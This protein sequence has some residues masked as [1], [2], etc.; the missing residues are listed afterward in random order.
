MVLLP[1]T[2]LLAALALDRLYELTKRSLVSMN[3]RATFVA[4]IAA[5]LLFLGMG[6]QN[7]NTYVNAKGSWATPGTSIGRY[8][9]DQPPDTRAY[10]V[11]TGYLYHD[12][13]FRFL[14]PGRLVASL[15]PE[16]AENDIAALSRPTLVILTREQRTLL[17]HLQ[18]DFPNGQAET[19][20][21]NTPSEVAFYV[22]RIP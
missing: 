2:A 22:F 21:G 1:P 6:I 17:A 14:A 12:R 9:A 8:L 4:P 20:V 18:Q 5:T 11:S 3:S 19:H 13:E 15:T 16:R 7:W 10:L